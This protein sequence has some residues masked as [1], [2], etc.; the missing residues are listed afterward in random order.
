MA[1]GGDWG[2][3]SHSTTRRF[4]GGWVSE[5]GAVWSGWAQGFGVGGL[6]ELGWVHEAA[7]CSVDAL[8]VVVF[9]TCCAVGGVWECIIMMLGGLILALVWV[10]V[11]VLI[12]TI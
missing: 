3:L 1:D 2:R 6:G 10:G 12:V 8:R 5:L 11:L 4:E 9:I 7:R